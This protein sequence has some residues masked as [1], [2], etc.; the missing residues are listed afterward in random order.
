MGRG[1]DKKYRGKLTHL[2]HPF[3]FDHGFGHFQSKDP[4][5][6]RAKKQQK[7]TPPAPIASN[8]A[9]SSVAVSNDKDV[10]LSYL[11]DPEISDAGDLS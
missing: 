11:P 6:V 5:K 2:K 8:T 10:G 3:H 9:G 4:S 1:D 7:N